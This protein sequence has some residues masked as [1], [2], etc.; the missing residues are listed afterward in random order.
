MWEWRPPE[1]LPTLIVPRLRLRRRRQLGTA[2]KL[3]C[4][5]GGSLQA[6]NLLE[7]GSREAPS[8]IAKQRSR[9]VNLQNML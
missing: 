9:E 3:D 1:D 7:D 6:Q 2:P 4:Q 5:S 8:D